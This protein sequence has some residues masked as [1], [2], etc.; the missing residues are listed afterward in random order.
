MVIT[1]EEMFG[2]VAPLYRHIGQHRRLEEAAALR[3]TLSA[4][5]MSMSGP[6]PYAEA[7]VRAEVLPT[8]SRL[9]PR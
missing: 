7:M 9:E 8:T 2:S 5:F 3:G 1:K 4:A 6:S